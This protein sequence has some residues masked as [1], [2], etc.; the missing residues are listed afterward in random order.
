MLNKNSISIFLFLKLFL[1]LIIITSLTPCGKEDKKTHNRV[2]IAVGI[3]TFSFFKTYITFVTN[4]N[5][6]VHIFTNYIMVPP[7]GQ[8]NT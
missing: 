3:E 8:T 5:S 7:S 2:L 6:F 4:T 1:E